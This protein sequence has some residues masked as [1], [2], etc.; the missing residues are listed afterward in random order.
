MS[1]CIKK[2]LPLFGFLVMILFE[3]IHFISYFYFKETELGN[4]FDTF[5]SSP[6]FD[7]YV[8]NEGCGAKE[9]ITFHIWGGLEDY[10]KEWGAKG[11]TEINRI[12]GYFFCYKKKCH[13]KNYYIII[14]L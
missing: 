3:T 7:F 14:K 1:K 2:S 5:E 13:I 4:I 9:Y 11:R 10:V 8:D 6:L 12:N